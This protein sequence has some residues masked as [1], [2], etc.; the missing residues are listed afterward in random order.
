MSDDHRLEQL[1][2]EYQRQHSRLTQLHHE[3][4]EISVTATSPRREVSVT[5][6][7]LGGVTDIKFTGTAY[8]RMTSH[9]LSALLLKTMAQAK[10]MAAEEAATII[11]PIVPNGMN[12][13]DLAAGRV[14]IET[15]AP[16][17]GPRLPQVVREQLLR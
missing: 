11:A 7:H 16:S 10:E 9:E 4:Q 2:D 3:L 13:R 8:K 14:D 5:A 17:T 12:P 15:L 6:S 1:L